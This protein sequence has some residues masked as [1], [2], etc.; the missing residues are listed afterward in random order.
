MG[1]EKPFRRYPRTCT[2][3]RIVE[4][5][6]LI[7]RLYFFVNWQKYY[8][9]D[10]YQLYVTHE[11]G[12]DN[13][14]RSKDFILMDVIDMNG[15]RL[16]YINDLLI[17]FNKRKVIG[18]NISTSSFFKKDLNVMNEN[19]VSYNSAM[20]ITEAVK[21]MFLQF[22]NIKGMDVRDKKGTIVG[23][24]EDILFEEENFSIKA[25]IIST[26]FIT[27]F[28]SGKKIVLINQLVLGEENLLYNW[29]NEHL[30]FSSIPHKL[31]M[32]ED[33][34]ERNKKKKTI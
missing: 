20:V 10:F 33:L 7:K 11:H 30:N 28:I 18:F 16:G 32:E 5:Y 1:N 17:D 31:F 19:I 2:R 21:G 29:Q 9:S 13:V 25:L 6:N 15:K 14:Y 23:M 24:V 4:K 8:I 34:D 22:K 3:R 27:N 26:G 12:G